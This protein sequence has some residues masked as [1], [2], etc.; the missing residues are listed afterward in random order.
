[1]TAQTAP[2]VAGSSRA[3][4]FTSSQ[5][6]L[7]DVNKKDSTMLANYPA[8]QYKAFANESEST[9]GLNCGTSF[10]RKGQN[11][12]KKSDETTN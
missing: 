8:Q 9:K 2:T 11:C 5:F 10:N 4:S 1:M 12:V 7:L 3:V 6:I